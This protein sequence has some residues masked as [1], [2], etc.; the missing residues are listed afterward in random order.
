M[1]VDEVNEKLMAPMGHSLDFTVAETY[2]QEEVSIRQVNPRYILQLSNN[3]NNYK[4]VRKEC[5]KL[6][7]I[8]EPKFFQSYCESERCRRLLFCHPYHN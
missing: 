5:P 8:R 1:A 6:Q 3:F 7:M 4:P 2:G